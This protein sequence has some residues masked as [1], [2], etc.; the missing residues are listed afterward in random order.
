MAF[1]VSPGVNITEKDL[2]NIVPAVATTPG[3]FV[4][5]FHW[6]PCE[7]IVTIPSENELARL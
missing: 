1:R 6:G 3:G 4:G 5:N 7:D 2:T